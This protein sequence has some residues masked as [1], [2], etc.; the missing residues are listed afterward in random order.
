MSVPLVT[1]SYDVGPYWQDHSASRSIDGVEE[2]TVKPQPKE[3]RHRWR[4]QQQHCSGPGAELWVS[5]LTG[6]A[7]QRKDNVM[8]YIFNVSRQVQVMCRVSSVKPV[9]YSSMYGSYKMALA[10]FNRMQATPVMALQYKWDMCCILP[11]LGAICYCLY[12]NPSVNDV[13]QEKNY[14]RLITCCKNSI[15]SFQKTEFHNLTTDTE[16]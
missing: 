10:A 13:I 8:G 7:T 1:N 2:S 6:P 5:R 16:L 3:N 9:S 4:W 12:S 14:D 11:G 15:I